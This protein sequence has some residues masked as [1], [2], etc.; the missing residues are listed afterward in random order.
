MLLIA[1][2]AQARGVSPY[3]PLNVAPEIEREIERLFTLAGMPILRK[4]YFAGD[5][6]NAL[7]RGCQ[8]PSSVCDK[9]AVYL[10][11]YKNNWGLTDASAT[12]LRDDDADKFVPNQRGRRV[13]SNY[14]ASANLFW[15]VSDHLL[16]N[17]SGVAY[18]DEVLPTGYLSAGFDFAQLD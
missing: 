11:R 13:D 12:A 8:V 2:T 15:Q 6:E 4:P 17:V 18:D 14:S 7:E 10:K 16:L 9:V 1:V 3:L 5:V